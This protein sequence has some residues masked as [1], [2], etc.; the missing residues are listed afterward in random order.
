MVEFGVS[1]LKGVS[2]SK[3]TTHF[4]LYDPLGRDPLHS[5]I[6]RLPTDAQR[7]FIIDEYTNECGDTLPCISRSASGESTDSSTTTTRH[8]HVHCLTLWEGV[9]VLPTTSLSC[10]G[11]LSDCQHCV[12]NVLPP[13]TTCTLTCQKDTHE[14]GH[15]SAAVMP[16]I[17]ISC[18]HH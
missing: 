5:I 16:L 18:T 14:V 3:H 15:T 8:N 10:C 12:S 7:H 11:L 4:V 2:G 13:S 17:P 6:D 9:F 1:V